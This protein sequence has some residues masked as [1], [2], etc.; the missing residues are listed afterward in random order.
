MSERKPIITLTTD[1]GE[2]DYYVPAMK[3]AIYTVNPAVEIV[4][5][6]HLVPPHD[7]Y[8]A[9][10]M[11]FCC[12]RDFPKNT[13][14]LVVV[15]PGVGSAR[16]PIMVM[17]DDYNFIGPDNGVFSY[18]YQRERVNRIV[19]FTATHYFKSPVSN[20][21]HGRDIFAPCAA[22]VSKLG[23]WRKMGEEIT[24]PV[25]F[26][27]PVP[28]VISDNQVKGHIIHIDRFG[29]IITNI[30]NAEISEERASSG[31]RVRVGKHEAARV[32]THFAEANKDELF[33]YFGS[34]GFL[35]L[36]VPRQQAARI[37]EAR[38]GMDVEVVLAPRE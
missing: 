28:A 4:D 5:L 18:I 19:H 8:S 16:R 35:E 20:T 25:R 13:L 32:L 1:F 21:F 14:H 29:N 7:I 15:D 23:D 2:A 22:Y 11:L 3:G 26:N 10:F 9:A 24:D 36:A 30:T 38:R 12:Y 37:V 6:T 17:T 33:A 31:A 34:A 27:V